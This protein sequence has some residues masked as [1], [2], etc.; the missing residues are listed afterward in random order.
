MAE[1][2]IKITTEQIVNEVGNV[3]DS[4]SALNVGI[5]ELTQSVMEVLNSNTSDF[6]DSMQELIY[7][8]GYIDALTLSQ[9]ISKFNESVN[10]AV[11]GFIQLDDNI[12]HREEVAS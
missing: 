11:Q 1:G 10:Q 7:Y 2:N 9:D 6:Y 3:S 5:E 12:I 8:V 4:L